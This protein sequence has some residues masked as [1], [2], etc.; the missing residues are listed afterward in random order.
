MPPR[1]TECRPPVRRCRPTAGRRT[2][3]GLLINLPTSPAPS[4]SLIYLYDFVSILKLTLLLGRDYAMIRFGIARFDMI[5]DGRICYTVED[6]F[7]L[8]VDISCARLARVSAD[9][10]EEAGGDMKESIGAST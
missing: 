2:E 7:A 3:A 6:R 4:I 10:L 9:V 1:P 8:R 5:Y